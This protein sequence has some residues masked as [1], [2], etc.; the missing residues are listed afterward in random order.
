PVIASLCN[1]KLSFL[2]I[3]VLL[4][5]ISAF[6]YKI[7][8]RNED[9]EDDKKNVAKEVFLVIRNKK[10]LKVIAVIIFFIWV[11]LSVMTYFVLYLI[12]AASL[13][14]TIAFV[15]LAFL[16]FG[17]AVGRAI[18]GAISDMFF[19]K[20]RGGVLGGIGI[21]SGLLLLLLSGVSSNVPII[22]IVSLSFLLGI[23]TQ[24]WNGI[25]VLLLSEVVD[26]KHVG[27]SSG[28]GLSVVYIGAILGTPLSGWI[29]DTINSYKGAWLIE[30][31]AMVFV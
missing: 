25:F 16:Q 10:L 19:Y 5:L 3:S 30:S 8:N 9:I 18:W 12:S 13:K 31:I 23:T 17:G 11:Q 14:T 27:I 15:C 7:L 22:L 6:H 28:V 26:K 24:G 1:W 21:L 2:T 4:F 20:K 29:I